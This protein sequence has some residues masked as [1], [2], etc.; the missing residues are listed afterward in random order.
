MAVM[1]RL[2]IIGLTGACAVISLHA[3]T[4][5]QGQ[6]DLATWFGF[7]GLEIV[8]IGRDAGPLQLG[9]VN[10]DGLLDVIAIN[11]FNSR[12]E[13]HYQRRDASPDD[14]PR[15]ATRINEF[16]EHWRFRR[17]NITVQHAIGGIVLHDFDDD[18]LQDFIYIGLP[19]EIV[20]LRQREPG[21]FETAARHR[22]KNIF[23]A[24]DAIAVA[25]VIGDRAE[26]LLT[27]SEG[28]INVWT[29]DG[30]R[31]EEAVSLSAGAN[32]VAFWLAD[33]DGNGRVDIA[34]A[35]P[36]DPSPLRMWMGETH[37][38]SVA[39]LGPQIRF[40]MPPIVEAETVLLPGQ[41]AANLAI[42][43]RTTKRVV[44]YELA[45]ETVA[46]SGDR[47]AALMSFS[48]TD[49]T[50]RERDVCIVD[51]NGDGLLDVVA[52]DASANAVAVFEQI[53]GRGLSRAAIHPS[54]ADLKA[55]AGGNVDDDPQAEL[56]LLSEKESVVGRSDFSEGTL[57]FPRPMALPQGTTPVAISLVTIDDAPCLAVVVKDGRN[58]QLCIMSMDGSMQNVDLGS[59]TRSPDAI[60]GLDADQD[61]R[62]DLLLL[63]R[64]KPMTMIARTDDGFQVRES[65]D[66]G[67]FGL[68][69][70]ATSEN[71]AVFDIDGDGALE[72][73]I[74]SRNFVRAVRFDEQ[75]QTGVSPGWQVIE[76]I[77]AR[78]AATKLVAV[79][80]SGDCIIAADGES[81]DLLIFARD[82]EDDDADTPTTWQQTERLHVEGM[83]YTEIYAGAF[84]G[85]GEENI[86][87][88]GQDGFAVVRLAGERITLKEVA[89]WRTDDERRRQHELTTGDVNGDG[90]LDMLSL[91]AGEQMLEIFTFS[92]AGNML[93]ATGFQ[94][95]ESRIFS[96]GAIREFQ[97]SQCLIGDVTGDG[98]NDIILLA[99]DRILLYPQMV[100]A[101]D[102]E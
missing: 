102:G 26:E 5:A 94:T 38:D 88:I 24:K 101:D 93:Y 48:F 19:S 44:L 97:P 67:Q 7:D 61:G 80:V 29:M 56:F 99:H 1:H 73:L 87:A 4:L 36:D 98:A 32:L 9:D 21:V 57:N 82:E 34:A 76:Q 79:A 28:K 55:V 89:A 41:T 52:T 49:P 69:Q 83:R 43:E 75:P 47:D 92:E 59:A 100:E 74:A 14:V 40:E 23:P 12:I 8:K 91:D 27:I 11:D 33:F 60:V 54:L 31:I 35:I 45:R 13:V 68:V 86:L 96:G 46:A 17:E 37:G 3:S 16:P 78:D 10:G 62:T 15:R 20:F 64:D 39:T 70:A 84:A 6:D 95:F 77:N 66:M 63:T 2:G 72:L 25:D 50:A 65:K 90:F 42:I 58:Y 30:S 71:T 18:G 81:G 85:D 51:V 53:A 22:V